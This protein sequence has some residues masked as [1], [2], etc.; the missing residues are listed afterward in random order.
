MSFEQNLARPVAQ[1]T[2]YGLLWGAD[3]EAIGSS[4]ADRIVS[5]DRAYMHLHVQRA[6]D[7]G[8]GYGTELVRRS[9]WTYLQL[10]ELARL[11]CEPHAFNFASN[12]TLRAAGF[13][14]VS[15]QG[16][17]PAPLNVQQVTNLWVFHPST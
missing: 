5:G 9:S 16:T 6:E 17:T 10:F 11:Y 7:R 4:T 2:D 8:K 14:Y 3:G 15:T 1:R 12:R 13:E